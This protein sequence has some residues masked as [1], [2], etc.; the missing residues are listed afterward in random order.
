[1]KNIQKLLVA[2]RGEIALRIMKT[3]RKM[4]LECVAVYSEAD[5]HSLHVKFADEAV[6]IGEASAADS[7]LRID[8]ILAAAKLTKAEAVHPGY[9][10]LSE[11]PDFAQAVVDAGLIFIGPTPKSIRAMGLKKEAKALVAQHGV[12]LVAGFDGGDQSLETLTTQCKKLG[13]PLILKP[14]AGG[15]GKGMKIVR[16]EF[17]IVAAIQSAKREAAK[18]F[19]NDAL[20]LDRALV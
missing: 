5:A 15:G 6:C 18:S 20:I 4:G 13:F 2:N 12:P 7:Y 19:G 17:E 3:A 8:K 9:G 11:N 14:S 16:S 1:M 10:F